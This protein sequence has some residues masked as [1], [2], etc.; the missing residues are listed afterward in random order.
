MTLE[1][2]ERSNTG[3]IQEKM[4][5]PS[6]RSAWILIPALSWGLDLMALEAPF[7]FHDSR[8]LQISIH[9]L[10]SKPAKA[11][12]ASIFIRT[13]KKIP[14]AHWGSGSSKTANEHNLIRS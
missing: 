11:P 3:G 9:E 2:S 6:V 7:Q 10:G 4:G 8:I 14:K 12:V 13:L 5:P 1:G